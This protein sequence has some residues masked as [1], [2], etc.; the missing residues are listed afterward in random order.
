MRRIF[1]FLTPVYYLIT[2]IRNFF[3]DHQ[4][5]DCR[6]V[7][8]PVVSVG[9]LTLG[10]TGKTPV[11][12]YLIKWCQKNNLK[13]GV[14]SRGY[15][16]TYTKVERVNLQKFSSLKE[17]ALFFGDEPTM[18]SVKNPEIP[19]FVC[20]DRY[21]GAQTLIDAENKIDFLLLD[22]GFQH[23]QLKRDFDLVLLDSTVCSSSYRLF[24]LGNAREPMTSLKRADYVILTKTNLADDY[25]WLIKEVNKYVSKE[26]IIEMEY[27][28][29]GLIRWNGDFK[30][31]EPD[32][33]KSLDQKS[34]VLMSAVGNPDSFEK[35]LVQE[36]KLN[37]AHH[38]V[39]SDHYEYKGE[40]LN[41]I[42][43]QCQQFQD[44]L[45]VLTEK[46]LVKIPE[47]F[48]T[49][50]KICGLQLELRPTSQVDFLYGLFNSVV[51]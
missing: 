32:T 39:F 34:L 46:D 2:V 47:V 33:V 31:F 40:D 35:L 51:C 8:V 12:D 7:S 20:R 6:S 27:K 49:E 45:L 25:Q 29:S 26:K 21:L 11:I 9:N 50:F 41:F 22:D 28:V 36:L 37:I 18:L 19:I 13:I 30:Q 16:G 4:I 3:Y 14:V 1:S 48:L 23:R 17:S 5:F 24:P 38:I 15:K 44:P 43:K 42:K 10:G